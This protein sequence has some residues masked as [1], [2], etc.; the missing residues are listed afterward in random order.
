[1]LR[2]LEVLYKLLKNKIGALIAYIATGFLW[3]FTIAVP[4]VIKKIGLA[5]VK[6]GIQK[7]ASATVYLIV[8][9]FVVLVFNFIHSVYVE[10]LNVLDIINNSP[11]SDPT[12]LL[13][14]FFNLMYVSGIAQGFNSAMS[15][16]ISVLIF[17]FLRAMYGIATK[18]S[19]IVS[20]EIGK[21][22]ANY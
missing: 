4:W 14:C 2:L 19:K 20:D 7:A 5:V 1:M 16:G 13:S 3:F 11:S 22:L 8:S 12:G 6:G 21:N 15:F 10:F 18:I 9:A 17:F